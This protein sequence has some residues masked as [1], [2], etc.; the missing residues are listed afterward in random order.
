MVDPVELLP[1]AVCRYIFLFLLGAKPPFGQGLF[2]TESYKWI[3]EADETVSQLILVSKLWKVT[4]GC[5]LQQYVGKLS[6]D[7]Y[8]RSEEPNVIP[9]MR[10][11]CR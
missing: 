1:G 10:W 6:L 3:C 5:M 2:E 11:V 9:I 8:H 7:R 4:F